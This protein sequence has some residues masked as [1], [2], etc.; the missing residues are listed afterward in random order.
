MRLHN[1]PSPNGQ[2]VT[3]FLAEKGL[4]IPTATVNL[5]EGEHLK[6]GYRALNS[7]CEVPALELDDGVVI[8]ETVAICRYLEQLHPEPPLFGTDAL[9]QAQVEMWNRRMEH[10]VYGAIAD[11]ARHEFEFFAGRG[12][13]KEYA[14]LR[15]ADFAKYARWL[16]QELSDG[17][18]YIVGERFSVADV[19]GMAMLYLMDL[20]KY[21]FPEDCAR[22]AR[23]ADSMRARPSFPKKQG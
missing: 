14:G 11:V 17:R 9:S 13:S 3:I 22:M 20:G 5:L 15:R 19:T 7:L 8:T 16:D 18:P 4:E 10:R 6:D 2:R 12:Q 21:A 1:F 23:W